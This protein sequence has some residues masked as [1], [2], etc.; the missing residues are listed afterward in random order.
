MASRA[1]VVVCSGRSHRVLQYGGHDDVSGSP[2][3][4]FVATRSRPNL[5]SRRGRLLWSLAELD[6]PYRMLGKLVELAR[7]GS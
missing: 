3:G 7:G 4:H 5:E 1:V 6:V 2:R